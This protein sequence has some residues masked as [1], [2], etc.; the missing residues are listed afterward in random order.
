MR[1]TTPTKAWTF[2]FDREHWNEDRLSAMIHAVPAG[3]IELIDYV[4][5]NQELFRSTKAF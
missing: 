5:E 1:G 2:F 4:C 3:R